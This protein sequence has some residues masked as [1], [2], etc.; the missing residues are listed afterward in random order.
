MMSLPHEKNKGMN[1]YG[2][3]NVL[4]NC[5]NLKSEVIFIN[6][7]TLECFETHNKISQLI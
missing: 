2:G 1:I 7:R 6:C 5:K 4:Q 3:I